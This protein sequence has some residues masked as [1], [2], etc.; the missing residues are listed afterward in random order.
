MLQA[1]RGATEVRGALGWSALLDGPVH[2]NAGGSLRHYL[3]GRLAVEP[4]I[5]YLYGNSTDKDVL[6]Q[7]N[8]SW[9]FRA[10]GAR[11]QPYAIGGA[12]IM[13]QIRP[14]F[15]DT[16]EHFSGGFGV[17]FWLNDRWYFAPEARIGW[18][19]I[20]RIQAGAGYRF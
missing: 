8:V 6:F 5:V 9:D 7:A 11:I 1:Q 10:P 15:S 18:E 2:F 19:P 20:V 3:T 17:K 14:R 13:R 4:E 12:G 16:S